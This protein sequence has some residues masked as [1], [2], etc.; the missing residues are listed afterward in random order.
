[1]D[2]SPADTALA[3]NDEQK[4][5][6]PA[7]PLIEIVLCVVGS[8]LST[9]FAPL[10][11][12]LMVV[13]VYLLRRPEEGKALWGVAA[14]LVPC[15]LLCLAD[16]VNLGSLALPQVVGALVM[17]LVLPGHIGITSVCACILGL[18]ALSLGTDA[19]LL[20]SFGSSLPSYVNATFDEMAQITQ[21][22][23][24]STGVGIT[25]S[26]AMQQS[27]DYMR[28]IWPLIYVGQ[29]AMSVLMGLVGLGIARRTSMARLYEAYV[30][31]DVP[32]WGMVLIAVCAVCWAVS[33]LGVTGA[34]T[35]ASAALCLFICLRVLYFLQGM[36]VAMSIMDKRGYGSIARILVIMALLLLEGS[37]YVVCVAGAIDAWAIF[38]KLPRHERDVTAQSVER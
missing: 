11:V 37:F 32:L 27:I 21:D 9:F 29:A 25:V 16:W 30:R 31:F 12:G 15:A 19:A 13:G 20:A 35:F 24:S 2:E 1:M 38:R 14:C 5:S 18:T 6:W 34:A 10:G 23:A 22:A 7:R 17:G 8:L 26:A 4:A 33:R 3:R 36:A 28:S